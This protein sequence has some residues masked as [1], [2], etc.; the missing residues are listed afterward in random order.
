MVK[1]FNVKKQQ[2]TRLSLLLNLVFCLLAGAVSCQHKK[3]EVSLVYQSD[4]A[5]AIVIPLSLV[6]N[7]ANSRLQQSVKVVL[8]GRKSKQGIFGEFV[9]VGNALHFQP[10]IPLSPGLGYDIFQD[11]RWIGHVKVPE[12]QGKAPELLAIYPQADTLPENQLKLYLRF[13]KP[14]RTGNALN[15]ICLLDKNKDT[16]QKVFL[17]LQPELWDASGTV[18]TLWLDPGR[19]KRSLVLNRELGNPLKKA[20]SY[21]LIVSNQWKDNRGIKLVKTYTK[22]FT[23]GNRDEQ[24][25]NITT[26][27]INNPKAAT[28]NALMIS[29]GEALDHY[30]LQEC[31]VVLD[32][33]GIEQKGKVTLSG[34]DNTWTF[35]PDEPW[36]SGHYQIQVAAKLED[37]AGNNLNR[38]FDRDL[39]K[40]TQQN[41]EFFVRRFEVRE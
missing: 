26:W 38:V 12:I 9:T 36:R 16:L 6:R 11:E 29:T 2:N 19:I 34:G 30:L 8:T 18:L 27:K 23:A 4:R 37:L 21:Q 40:D 1:I 25:P 14:M 7:A 31:I 39:H 41:K 35:T 22:R 13:S 17:N 24:I 33:K 10:L 20:E 15:F 28:K 32:D 3:D 5:T